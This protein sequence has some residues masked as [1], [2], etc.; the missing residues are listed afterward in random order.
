[1]D[2]REDIA[3]RGRGNTGIRVLLLCLTVLLGM[4]AGV[5][6]FT[7]GYA[8]GLSYLS[9]EPTACT[10]CHVMEDFYDS[11]QNSSHHHVATCNDCH[12][13]DGVVRK[14]V[15][16]TDNGFFHSLA[17]TTDNFDEPIRIK[18]RNRVVAQKSCISCHS[19]LVDHMRPAEPNRQMPLCT[20]CHASVG[21]GLR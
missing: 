9:D 19:D 13:P 2:R 11:W 10:N 5:G 15:V 8:N 20:H 12:L 14:Y 1:M 16:K 6:V 7:F 18:E 3:G 17:F 4:L 21:H